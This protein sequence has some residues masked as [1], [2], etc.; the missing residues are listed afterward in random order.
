MTRSTL[1]IMLFKAI[2]LYFQAIVTACMFI[3][4]F[5]PYANYKLQDEYIQKI[6]YDILHTDLTLLSPPPFTTV[7]ND[8]S[9]CQIKHR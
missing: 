9:V 4:L 2:P 1:H 5:D 8:I 6:N 3:L 7:S